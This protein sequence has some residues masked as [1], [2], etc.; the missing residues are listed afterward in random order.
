MLVEGACTNG[1][2]LVCSVREGRLRGVVVKGMLRAT[3]PRC[4]GEIVV[5]LESSV[6]T[7]ALPSSR[8][9]AG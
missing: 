7:L 9:E 6:L 1:H 2:E 5:E 3:C 8:R 4:G